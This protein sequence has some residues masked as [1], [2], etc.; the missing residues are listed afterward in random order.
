MLLHSVDLPASSTYIVRLKL[1]FASFQPQKSILVG[2]RNT[3]G[4]LHQ[5]Q[6][7]PKL[8][9]CWHYTRKWSNMRSQKS[10]S[11]HLTSVS[12]ALIEAAGVW[13]HKNEQDRF[14]RRTKRKKF[15]ECDTVSPS[16]ILC[17]KFCCFTAMLYL[18]KHIQ[19][20]IF[21]ILVNL[22]IKN[23]VGS[24]HRWYVNDEV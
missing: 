11:S 14:Q 22:W 2:L 9:D 3:I 15:Y 4:R 23:T 21:V 12:S 16:A 18:L 24:T 13:N 7:V 8:A 20:E 17:T 6:K 19:Y 10:M 5:L 1:S